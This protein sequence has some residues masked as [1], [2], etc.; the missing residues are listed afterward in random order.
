MSKSNCG[1]LGADDWG[2]GTGENCLEGIDTLAVKE[3]Y[4]AL[5]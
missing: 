1:Y 3:N 2:M 5:C 4:I